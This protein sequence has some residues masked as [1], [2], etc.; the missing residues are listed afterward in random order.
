M[1]QLFS[2]QVSECVTQVREIAKNSSESAGISWQRGF[3]FYTMKYV[4]VSHELSYCEHIHAA[5]KKELALTN[6]NQAH[7]YMRNMMTNT[8][9]PDFIKDNVDTDLKL[10]S[11]KGNGELAHFICYIP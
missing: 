1:E 11:T 6:D 8:Q 4:N 2:T 3:A 10:L 5:V 7:W 9:A